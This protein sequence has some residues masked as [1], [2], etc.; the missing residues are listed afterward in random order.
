MIK[1]FTIFL[2]IIIPTYLF[3]QVAED[4]YRLYLSD[5]ENNSFSLESPEEFLSTESIQRRIKQNISIIENDLPVSNYY[6]DSLKNLGFRILNKSKWLNTVVVYS[7][8]QQLIDTITSYGFIK[9]KNKSFVNLDSKSYLDLLKNQNFDAYSSDNVNYGNGTTQISMINGHALHQ[10]GYQGQGITIAVIDGGFEG[11]NTL[12]AFDS[13]WQNNQI[14]GTRDFVDG[15]NEVFD[16]SDHGMKVLSTMGANIPGSLVGTAP[17]ANYWLLRSE[18][19]DDENSIEE[20]NWAAAAEFA[21]S[22]GIDIITSSLGY[23][24]FDKEYQNYS[25]NDLDGNSTFI[26][27]AADIAAS[28]GILVVNSA[29]N[30]GNDAWKYI[31]APGDGDS[32]LT[33]GAVDAFASI[34]YFSGLGPTYDGRIKPNVC[35][36]GVQSAVQSLDGNITVSN[37]TSFSTP[38]IAGMTA[39]L[40]QRHPELNNMEIIKKIEESAHQYSTPDNIM[41]YG[42]PDFAKAAELLNAT[43]VSIIND[44]AIIT[45][46]PNP[47]IDK[48]SIELVSK[49]NANSK[50]ELYNSIGIK[51]RTS[52]IER[53]SNNSIIELS[54]LNNLPKGIYF[55]RMEIGNQQ[56]TKTISKIK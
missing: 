54:N 48:V 5:K 33:V 45:V 39:C 22:L 38:I 2:F 6:I 12:P 36:M 50:I 25:Y 14:L 15:D 18:K 17:K 23:T 53:N 29:G 56:L 11:A 51:V 20:D 41:G 34:A 26:T 31:S 1:I 52:N 35:A 7:T 16:A 8:D 27:K 43:N 46:Y 24:E 13:L 44:K 49:I 55:I 30:L 19:T 10:N 3:S 32:V 42:I 21:D 47:F 4:R 9:S 37:G 28:K 40:W